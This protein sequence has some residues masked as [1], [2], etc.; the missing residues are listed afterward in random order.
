MLKQLLVLI[1]IHGVFAAPPQV[2]GQPTAR[3]FDVQKLAEGVFAVIRTEPP[4]LMFDANN[5]F[6]INDDHVV[7]VDANFSLASTREV[8]A[9][10]RQLTDKP[11][12]YVVNTH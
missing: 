3:N 7:V 1:F 8:L 12:R 6:I 5:V 2:Q 4:G 9:A 10:L 11:V